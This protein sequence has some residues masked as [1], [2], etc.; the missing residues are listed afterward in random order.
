MSEATHCVMTAQQNLQFQANC[1]EPSSRSKGKKTT[2]LL[3]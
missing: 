1:T 3:G 2:S